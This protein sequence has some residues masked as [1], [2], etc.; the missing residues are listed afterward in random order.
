MA[1]KKSEEE[2]KA[3]SPEWMVTFTDLVTLLMTFFVLLYSMS[4]LETSKFASMASSLRSSFNIFSNSG[5]M[6][7]NAGDQVF[8]IT[9]RTNALSDAETPLPERGSREYV[10]LLENAVINLRTEVDS[11]NGDLSEALSDADRLER[12]LRDGMDTQLDNGI[13]P[14]ELTEEDIKQMEIRAARQRKLDNFMQDILSETERLGIGGYVSIVSEED[15]LVLRLNSQILFGSGSASL[16]GKGLTVMLALGDCFRDLDH[17]IEVQGHTDDI[18]IKTSQFPSNWELSTQRA[19]NVVRILQDECGVPP[20]RLSS[21]G[22]GEY[23]PI[24][25]NATAEGRQSNRRID[26]VITTP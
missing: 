23:Q 3:G 17:L 21:T 22:F 12:Q 14:V 2:A 11:L 26:I 8:S 13:K 24:G 4:S 1:R 6:N 25:D 5:L 20:T 15:R 9:D 18:P 19:T 16:G 10:E 7:S